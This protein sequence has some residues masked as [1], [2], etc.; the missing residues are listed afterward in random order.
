MMVTLARSIMGCIFLMLLLSAGSE[1]RP[2]NPTM[3]SNMLRRS[4][5]TPIRPITEASEVY[6]NKRLSPGGPDAHHH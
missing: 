3:V 2:L 5:G 1:T 4:I 6:G